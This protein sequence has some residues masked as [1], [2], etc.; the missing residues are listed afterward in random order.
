[1]RNDRLIPGTVLV[2]IGVLFLLN[3]FNVIDFNWFSLFHLWPILLVIGGVNLIFAHNRTPVA[4]AVKIGVLIVGM[5]ILIYSG[6]NKHNDYGRDNWRSVFRHFDRDYTDTT[7][8]DNDS[9]NIGST[10]AGHYLETYKPEIKEAVLNINGGAT[11]YILKDTTN[12]LFE[13]DTKGLSGMYS[14][15][16]N[17]DS[18]IQ[19]LDFDM[20][21]NNN[22]RRHHGFNFTFGNSHGKA[23]TAFLK[24]NSAPEWKINVEAGAA[25]IDF[26]LTK[27][28]IRNLTLE[29]GAAAF[30][31]KMGEPLAQTNLDISTGVSSITIFIPKGAACHITTDTGLSS[32]HINGFNNVGDDEYETAG[33]DKATKKM[34]INLSGAISD[35][36]V[37][38][39]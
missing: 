1:M 30:D 3:S 33:F 24:L 27:F 4:T 15:K 11:R 39:Y 28:K 17:S 12:N 22:N 32:K 20:D 6:L 7:D 23:N 21:G 8:N 5:G 16:S 35:F 26:D 31:V 38:Q 9:I 25:K 13:A 10:N 37:N 2:I 18:T 34:Y 29:G 36:K 19:T 14:L